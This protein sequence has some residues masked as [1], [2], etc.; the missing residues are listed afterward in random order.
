MG[1][2]PVT[3][4]KG[5]FLFFFFFK[6]DICI[7]LWQKKWKTKNEHLSQ[8]CVEAVSPPGAA[9][10]RNNLNA[11]HFLRVKMHVSVCVCLA[12]FFVVIISFC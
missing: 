5:F 8:L 10:T 9:V 2:L 7:F 6:K 4:E 1:R 12:G 11:L 3:Q